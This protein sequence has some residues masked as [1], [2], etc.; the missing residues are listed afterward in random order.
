[1][2]FGI[3][4]AP[5]IFQEMMERVIQ[6]MKENPR[7]AELLQP[8]NGQKQCFLGA[9]FDDVGVGSSTKEEHLFLLEELFK[10]VQKHRLRIK[11]PKCDLL[12]ESLEYFG[13]DV[14]WGSWKPSEKRTESLPNFV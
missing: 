10:I 11:L 5:A 3:Q 8:K 9:F 7:V 13:F 4:S 14:F 1:M 6:E 2:P 12:R